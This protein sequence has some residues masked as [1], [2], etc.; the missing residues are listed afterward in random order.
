MEKVH[1]VQKSAKKSNLNFRAK[2][3]VF[4]VWFQMLNFCAKI[5]NR[6]GIKNFTDEKFVKVCLHF[7]DSVQFEFSRQKCQIRK[8]FKP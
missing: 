1:Y 5:Q 8:A 4:S 3:H 2:I 7:S 6:I